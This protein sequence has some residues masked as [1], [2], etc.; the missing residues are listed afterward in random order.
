MRAN[1]PA[2]EPEEGEPLH[3]QSWSWTRTVPCSPRWVSCTPVWLVA[4]EEEAERQ[5]AQPGEGG[6]AAAGANGVPA[7]VSVDA[8]ADLRQ[9]DQ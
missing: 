2:P 9:P 3:G 8:S 1:K 6:G 4:F 5:A 7:D